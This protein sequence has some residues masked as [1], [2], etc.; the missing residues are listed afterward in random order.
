MLLFQAVILELEPVDPGL[1]LQG[2]YMDLRYATTPML[3]DE[4]ISKNGYCILKLDENG[5]G[6]K[7]RLQHDLMPLNDGEYAIVYTSKQSLEYYVI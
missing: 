4:G 7:I 1:L 2:D 3:Y 6:D 5:T